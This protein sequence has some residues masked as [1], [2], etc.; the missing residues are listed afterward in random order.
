MNSVIKI[1]PVNI[2][3][4]DRS[5]GRAL[6]YYV[7]SLG[8]EGPQAPICSDVEL[9]A[10]GSVTDLEIVI[11][12]ERALSLTSDKVSLAENGLGAVLE[13]LQIHQLKHRIVSVNL[14]DCGTEANGPL[15][16]FSVLRHKLEMISGFVPENAKGHVYV[17]DF[18]EDIDFGEPIAFFDTAE[19]AFHRHVEVYMNKALASLNRTFREDDPP[20]FGLPDN[21]RLDKDLSRLERLHRA[22]VQ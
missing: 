21:S 11:F 3:L 1:I 8:I 15:S 6:R 2:D 4:S 22:V 18:D 12:F 17:I 14:V 7:R 5:F 9:S 13:L 16:N 10:V 19:A 20:S